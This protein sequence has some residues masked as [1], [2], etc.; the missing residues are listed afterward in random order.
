M[1]KHPASAATVGN[2]MQKDMANSGDDEIF[3]VKI[4]IILLL[5]LY[6][7]VVEGQIA[8]YADH[9]DIADQLAECRQKINGINHQVLK[10]A[11]FITN[12]SYENF[13]TIQPATENPQDNSL[14]YYD[15]EGR[16][17]K[18][19]F[20]DEFEQMS[21]TYF[22]ETGNLIFSFYYN[23][24]EG[25]LI[26]SVIYASRQTLVSIDMTVIYPEKNIQKMEYKQ[27][28]GNIPAS[29]NGFA[30]G[31]VS[32]VDSIVK[33][34]HMPENCPKVVFDIRENDEV[35]MLMP[36][37]PVHLSP[38]FSSEVTDTL[39]ALQAT[40][41]RKDMEDGSDDDEFYHWYKVRYHSWKGESEGYIFGAYIEPAEHKIEE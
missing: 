20:E 21:I 40:I 34:L 32:Y 8:G 24:Y 14:F 27:Y 33:G 30:T 10:K 39:Q 9:V 7:Q 18:E 31:A 41:I 26:S 28:G 3:I 35:R 23:P 12:Q 19:L 11:M 16:I 6:G 36:D 1:K 37:V 2:H 13:G 17:R 5:L 22:D 29:I 25:E 4:K 38:A 15:A